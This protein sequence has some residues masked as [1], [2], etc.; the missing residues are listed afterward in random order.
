[1]SALLWEADGYAEKAHEGQ[2]RDDGVTPYMTHPRQVA[3][4]IAQVTDDENMIAAA[5]LHDVIEDTAI[6]YEDL[7]IDFGEDIANLVNEVSHEGKP[8]SKGYYFPRL[9]TQRGIMLKFAD[10]LSNLSDMAS[11]DEKRRE[12]YLRKSKFWKD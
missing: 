8:D 1:M 6:T 2:F 9:K 5:L 4:I 7:V 11:W 10:R 12:H 3:T